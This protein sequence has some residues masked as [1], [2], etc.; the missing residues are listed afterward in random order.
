MKEMSAPA[1]LATATEKQLQAAVV[2]LA[3]FRGWLPIHIRNMIGNPSGLPDLILL[4]DGRAVF[5]EL[6][7]EGGRLGPRQ[8]E[9]IARLAGVGFEVRVWFPSDW[10]E[11]ERTLRDE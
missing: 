10:P 6:K 4:K 11:I 1:F 9:W 3:R 5:A 8:Q 7:R 2:E